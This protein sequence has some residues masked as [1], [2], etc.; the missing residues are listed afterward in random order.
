MGTL[1]NIFS[2]VFG[3]PKEFIGKASLLKNLPLPL[4]A[5]SRKLSGPLVKGG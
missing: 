3:I 2:L 5:K 1:N 4:F